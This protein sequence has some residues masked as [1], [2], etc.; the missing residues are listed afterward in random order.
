MQ[1]DTIRVDTL[2]QGYLIECKEGFV[3]F[4]GVNLLKG[5]DA[6]G[7]LRHVLVDTGH[8][9]RR[10]Q[11]LR[12]LAV[13]GLTP[14]DIDMLVCTHAHW[15][16]MENLDLFDRAQILIHRN[17]RRYLK[18]PHRND[19]ACPGWMEAVFDR[20]DDR[21]VEVE[22]G[23]RLLPGIEVLDA[24]GHSAG[25]MAIAARV[26]DGVG[27]VAGDAI[28]SSAVA[29]EKRNSLVFWNEAEANRTVDK[30]V[31]VAD[32][33]YPGH[34]RPFRI[35]PGD[36]VEYVCDF[37]LT[38]LHAGPTVPGVQFDPFPEFRPSIMPG[39]EEQ[40]LLG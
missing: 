17:E 37:E 7:E 31:S 36:K 5:P 23:D 39:I 1:D 27:V 20:Y 33:I 26:E 12:E 18:R 8:T 34:D 15:D 28:Q 29:V 10:P 2:L 22:E 40:R 3:G 38:V 11:L 16:H 13:R 4:C 19:T 6:A 14:S 25:S 9:G 30:L 21:I 32:I 24:P 35:G